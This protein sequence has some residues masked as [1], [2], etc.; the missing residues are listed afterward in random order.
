VNGEF[1][2]PVVQKDQWNPILSLQS[3][4]LA[5]EIFVDE[6]INQTS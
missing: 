2:L 3:I 4:I 5:L 1:L 6:R